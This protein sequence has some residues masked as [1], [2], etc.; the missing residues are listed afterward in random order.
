MMGVGR[1][2]REAPC[3]PSGRKPGLEKQEART[4]VDRRAGGTGP[5][6]CAVPGPCGELGLDLAGEQCGHYSPKPP[7]KL[8]KP[9]RCFSSLVSKHA[10]V[11]AL[12]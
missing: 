5:R 1:S 4:D 3:V 2:G 7:F 6:I 11:L 12:H 9:T 8:A 10:E